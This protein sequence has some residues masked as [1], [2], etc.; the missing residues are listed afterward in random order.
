ML[1]IQLTPLQEL[2]TPRLHLRALSPT[3]APELLFLRSDPAVMRY[4]QKAP[5]TSL[6]QVQ[7]HLQLLDKQL[8]SNQGITWGI[9]R[10]PHPQ[11]IGSIC[12]WNLQPAHHRAEVG[13]DLHP[14]LWQQGF[15]SE[16]LTA[17]LD[18][19]FGTL[20]LHSIEANLSPDNT[21]S[22]RLLEKHGFQREGHLRE[23]YCFNGQFFDTLVYA[24]LAPSPDAAPGPA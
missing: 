17:V 14:A 12:L 19:G 1:D 7:Q 23:N 15:M 5:D 13:Y 9:C 10:P 22:R 4:L 24:R 11:L 16:A 20:R 6:E 8:A 3:D 2:R 18:F 21:A